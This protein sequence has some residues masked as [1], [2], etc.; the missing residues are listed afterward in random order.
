[1]ISIADSSSMKWLLKLLAII[2][3]V[4]YL[5]LDECSFSLNYVVHR[6][7]CRYGP[8]ENPRVFYKVHNKH[9]QK[10]NVWK[11]IYGNHII[12]PFF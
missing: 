5:F 1:M 4:R 12:G 10:L 3:E 7:Y 11:G 2:V 8:D 9:T 6:H